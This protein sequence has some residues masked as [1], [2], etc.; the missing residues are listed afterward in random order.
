[1]KILLASNSPRRKE[2]LAKGN[3]DFA[4]VKS[5]Y[6]EESFKFY[7]ESFI[8]KNSLYKALDAANGIDFS[9]V[10]IGADTMVILEEGMCD[11]CLL[12]P[13]DYKEAFLMLKKLSGKTH[14]VVTSISLVKTPA[15]SKS[16]PV[17]NAF[18]HLTE[19]EETFVTFRKLEDDEIRQY[20]DIFKPFDK[21]GSYGIQDFCTQGK[22]HGE[23]TLSDVFKTKMPNME[24]FIEKIDGDYFNVMGISVNKLK[25]ML[26]KL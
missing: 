26:A 10:I 18:E 20:L 6:K 25:E 22:A 3:I 4:V 16:N 7:N 24:S 21:A 12:K 13:Q 14:K 8:K 5:N 9:A 23:L 2:I 11:V 17:E 1:M 15:F 19:I